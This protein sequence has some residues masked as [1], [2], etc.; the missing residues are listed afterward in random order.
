MNDKLT[1]GSLISKALRKPWVPVFIGILAMFA[2][3]AISQPAFLRLNNF[4]NILGQCSMYGIMAVGMVFII[5]TGGIDISVGMSAFFTMA[6]MYQVAKVLPAPLVF[7]VAILTSTSVGLIN[8]LLVTYLRIPAMIATLATMSVTRGLAYILINS[9][10]KMIPPEL[11]IIGGSKIGIIPL[12]SILMLAIAIIGAFL[13]NRTRFGRYVIAIGDNE[14]SAAY[15]GMPIS[16]VRLGAY[17]FCGFC[18]GVAAIVYAGRVGSIQPDSC[19]G[20][21][22]TVI[23]A[24]VLGGTRM[25]GGRSSVCGAVLGAIFL[26]LG[27]NA[28]TML[29]VSS[30]YQVFCRGAIMFVAIAIDTFTTLRQRKAAARERARRLETMS[31]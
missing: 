12:A 25:T 5:S 7:L 29:Q 24:V 23:T 14:G 27:E 26:Y 20:Y 22:F 16:L 9:T 18:V 1:T 2:F 3:L 28:L 6:V 30:Y 31:A 11:R 15:T 13:L 19:L 21:E 17:A 10:N 8:G 4:V